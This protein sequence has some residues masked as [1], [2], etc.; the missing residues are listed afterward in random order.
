MW[1]Y[2]SQKVKSSSHI[3]T[4]VPLFSSITCPLG[5]WLEQLWHFGAQFRTWIVAD[6][7][8]SFRGD[9]RMGQDQ[10]PPC[11]VPS[12]AAAVLLP[13]AQEVESQSLDPTSSAH[14][15]E[16]LSGTWPCGS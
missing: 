6:H 1:E 3:S 7:G 14:G 15:S 10:G 11:C 13:R 8:A 12:G 5:L 16:G 9:V 2:L 4:R